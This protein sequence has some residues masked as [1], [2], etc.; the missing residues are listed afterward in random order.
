[1]VLSIAFQNGMEILKRHLFL[2]CWCPVGALLMD[3]PRAT[4]LNNPSS[5]TDYFIPLIGAWA[6]HCGVLQ[7]SAIGIGFYLPYEFIGWVFGYGDWTVRY[8]QAMIFVAV[9]CLAWLMLS[10]RFG[11]WLP[12]LATAYLSLYATSPFNVGDSPF[13][14]YGSLYYDFLPIAL[15]QLAI[16]CAFFPSSRKTLDLIVICCLLCYASTVKINLALMDTALVTAAFI[17]LRRDFYGA[18]P[19]IAVGCVA[20]IQLFN[21]DFARAS[22][23]RL[24]NLFTEPI[25]YLYGNLT[26]GVAGLY[27]RIANLVRD[28]FWIWSIPTVAIIVML[29]KTG[30]Q[31]M[32]FAILLALIAGADILRSLTNSVGVTWPFTVLMVLAYLNN[33]K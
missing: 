13:V 16:L 9:S 22:Q 15:G 5:G 26:Y 1:M 33:Q 27:S 18:I 31:A 21:P 30:K 17:L 10:I 23:A 19:V 6:L 20:A 29:S 14:P 24:Q 12:A 8:T 32:P 25:P 28:T 4:V 3:L 11:G 7:H 2:L